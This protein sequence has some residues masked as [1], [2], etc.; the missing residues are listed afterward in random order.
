MKF[1]TFGE[2]DSSISKN[3]SSNSDMKPLSIEVVDSVVYILVTGDWLKDIEPI[4]ESLFS[5][6][7]FVGV[8]VNFRD[9]L[10]ACLFTTGEGKSNSS[11]SKFSILVAETVGL[12]KLVEASSSANG[13]PK[14]KFLEQTF[15]ED[16]VRPLDMMSGLSVEII[17]YLVHSSKLSASNSCSR[18]CRVSISSRSCVISFS[19]T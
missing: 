9:F 1:S 12:L 13:A 4:L 15:L 2:F 11:S 14:T 7:S 17:S 6:V 19:G 18:S 16:V 3:G 10:A 8:S 5:C